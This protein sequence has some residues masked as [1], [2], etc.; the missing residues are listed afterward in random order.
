MLSY[1]A[2]FYP[3]SK[4][5]MFREERKREEGVNGHHKTELGI[6]DTILDLHVYKT[7]SANRSKEG[8]ISRRIQPTLTADLIPV[9]NP[10]I[11]V[12]IQDL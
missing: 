5:R 6:H 9:G 10:L 12:S 2:N 1:P 8:R 3:R 7:V 11:D 4:L